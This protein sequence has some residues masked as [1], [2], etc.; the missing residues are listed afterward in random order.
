[1]NGDPTR[2]HTEQLK[3]KVEKIPP[4]HLRDLHYKL[5]NKAVRVHP[6]VEGCAVEQIIPR[7]SGGARKLEKS[8]LNSERACLCTASAFFVITRV[9]FVLGTLSTTLSTLTICVSLIILL[10]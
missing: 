4:Q 7:E 2:W 6:R 1:M 10:H 8:V 3:E 5:A 9:Y